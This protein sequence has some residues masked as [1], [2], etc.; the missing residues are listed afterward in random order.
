MRV[1]GSY[2][3][4]SVVDSYGISGGQAAGEETEQHRLSCLNALTEL[5]A[6]QA[7]LHPAV[8]FDVDASAERPARALVAAG[9]D[10]DLVVVGTSGTGPV[11]QFLLGSVVAEVLHDSLCPVAVVGAHVPERIARVVVAADGSDC[12][13]DALVWATEEAARWDAELVVFHAWDYPYRLTETSFERGCDIVRIDAAL[14][15]E[16]AVAVA[17][18]RYVGPVSGLVAEG[19][20]AQCLLDESERADLLVLGSRGR[21]GFRSMLFGSVAH[22]VTTRSVCPVVVTR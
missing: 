20:A 6:E 4:V 9:R 19:G 22:A 15:V 2:G 13:Q 1:V 12:A 17:R 7:H 21:G 18:E 11:R 14:L 10:A 5:T 8:G 3:A 16:Q